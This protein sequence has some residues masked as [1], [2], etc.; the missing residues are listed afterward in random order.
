MKKILVMFLI[1]ALFSVWGC[2]VN[3]GTE[4]SQNNNAQNTA[5]NNV[6]QPIKLDK[7]LT[8]VESIEIVSGETVKKTFNKSDSEFIELV[9]ELKTLDYRRT[10][11]LDGRSYNFIR[12]NY[13]KNNYA[14]IDCYFVKVCNNGIGEIENICCDQSQYSEIINKY[15]QNNVNE[16]NSNETIKLDKYLTNVESIE[17]VSGESVKKTFNK[18]DS[19]FIELVNELKNLDYHLTPPLNGR[20]YNFIRFNYSENNYAIIDC[21]FVK[22]CNNGVGE[23]EN[24][25]C[26]QSQYGKIVNKYIQNNNQGTDDLNTT[27]VRSG[28]SSS[29]NSEPTLP[30]WCA[31]QMTRSLNEKDES[32]NVDLSFGIEAG[33]I[34]IESEWKNCNRFVVG[35]RNQDEE[36]FVLEEL[37]AEQFFTE[38]YK[39]EI[40]YFY[41]DTSEGREQDYVTYNYSNR[42]AFQIPSSLCNKSEGYLTFYLYA[43]NEETFCGGGAET[44]YYTKINGTI[45][46]Q[47]YIE[48]YS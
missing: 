29:E 8:N 12:F 22:V 11:P 40:D 31:Y 42:A 9:N 36:N 2:S 10:P 1:V 33:Y 38:K 28:Y 46:F 43:L 27:I 5:N 44:V 39:V 13:S 4:N 6:N 19:E 25:C 21:Y 32:I 34:N 24:I 45:Q 3:N 47:N 48:Y 23:I 15:I 7:Y 41:K 16:P 37:T 14:I 30:F 35:V 18:G 20:S 17:I 26:D